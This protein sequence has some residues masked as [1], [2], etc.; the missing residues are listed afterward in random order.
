MAYSTLVSLERTIDQILNHNQLSISPHEKEHIISLDK[1]VISLRAFLENF[2][3][4]AKSLE[5]RM[6]DAAMEAEDV[7]ELYMSEKLSFNIR[8]THWI[9]KIMFNIRYSHWIAELS[10]IK[11]IFQLRRARDRMDS[12]TGEVV[13]IKNGIVIK[14]AQPDDIVGASS[15][16]PR[17]PEAGKIN[18]VGLDEDLLEIKAW[19]CGDSRQLQILPITGMGGIGK[20]TLARN[21]YD[22]PLI[23]E[24]FHIRAW[25]TV[26]QDYSEGR[27]LSDLLDCLKEFDKEWKN[28]EISRKS[29]SKMAEKIYKILV[30]RKF[31]IVMDD[32]WST[33]LLDD[34]KRLF[35]NNN[36]RSRILLT[37]RL[38]DVAAY[39][40]SSRPPHEMSLADADQSWNLLRG[41]VFGCQDPVPREL[42]TTGR[43]IA[44][45]CGG[46]PL[47]VVVVAGLLST[48]SKT[49]TSWEEI[50]KNV[51]SAL[52]TTDGQ[53][54]K[55]LSLSYNHLPH[56][57]RPCFL[58]MGGFPE[59]HENKVLDLMRLWIAEGFVKPVASQSFEDTAEEYLE[60]LIKR[61][62]I[63]VSK[64][65]SNGKIK[66]CSLHDLVRDLCL[67]QSQ[68]EKFLVHVKGGRA[69]ELKKSMKDERRIS[70]S[71][72]DETDSFASIFSSTIRTILYFQDEIV[73]F[74]SFRLLRVLDVLR[75]E[76]TSSRLVPAQFFE[77][78]H[79]RYLA[80]CCNDP[81]PSAISNL[82]SLQTLIINNIFQFADLPREIWNMP[83][84][85]HLCFLPSIHL[86]YYRDGATLSL[87]NLQTLGKLSDVVFLSSLLDMIPNIKKLSLSYDVHVRDLLFHN[88][89]HLE[90]LKLEL[91]D[92]REYAYVHNLSLPSSLR[93]LALTGWGR[94]NR[95]LNIVGPLPNLEVLK[96]RQFGFEKQEW[97]TRDQDFSK[98]RFLLIEQS[99]LKHWNSEGSHFP[100]LEHLL[101]HSCWSLSDIPDDMGEIQTLKLIEVKNCKKSL[102]DFVKLIR[103]EQQNYG[104]DVFEVRCINY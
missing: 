70:I 30:E 60:Y 33:K 104:D 27:I 26:S 22:D 55:I 99:N 87:Q 101:I 57:L 66:N 35:P 18:M 40:D 63:I 54:Q 45:S 9:E 74:G 89:V 59:D 86:P 90:N 96:L 77:L 97:I 95:Y 25:V 82:Q 2:P 38:G 102:A 4:K 1:Y 34:V 50:A 36:N 51:K 68:E 52:A 65:K 46:L 13:E 56:H 19:L 7:I 64:S 12:I 76:Y 29:N 79:L 84:L 6:R 91:T 42:E 94:Y 78:F 83:Q 31:L 20:T 3:E 32:I 37:T 43:E 11:F 17:V 14:D 24:H 92:L 103:E 16:S 69:R 48:V 71:Q 72:F 28:E 62:L 67:K 44:R 39:A 93:K 73:S 8:Y 41:K 100:L 5:A 98:L 75:V 47:A 15:S 49:K 58:Y 21:A 85:R 81:I 61:S 53:V 88:L 80:F 10:R 23:M